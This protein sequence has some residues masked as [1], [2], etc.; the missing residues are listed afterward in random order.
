MKQQ[1]TGEHHRTGRVR[2]GQGRAHTG[3]TREVER[4]GGRGRE[5]RESQHFTTT[6]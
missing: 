5:T 2:S 4:E 1:W 6:D 3:T